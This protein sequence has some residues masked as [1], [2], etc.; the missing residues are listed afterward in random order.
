M[1]ADSVYVLLLSR[2]DVNTKPGCV[3]VIKHDP[4]FA[5]T[6]VLGRA[7]YEQSKYDYIYNIHISSGS[8]STFASIFTG[9]FQDKRNVK[10]EII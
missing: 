3:C 6:C 9:P 8:S 1:T 10:S 5:E 2:C 7:T 4:I